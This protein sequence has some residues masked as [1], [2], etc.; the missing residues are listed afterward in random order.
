[1]IAV[2]ARRT[3]TFSLLTRQLLFGEFVRHYSERV[4]CSPLRRLIE[5]LP[6]R[7][8]QSLGQTDTQILESHDEVVSK[9]WIQPRLALS[10]PLS[11]ITS[12]APS[13]S[14]GVRHLECAGMGDSDVV[15]SLRRSAVSAFSAFGFNVENAEGRRDSRKDTVGH[16]A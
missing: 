12:F 9:S 2:L 14:A 16:S 7:V 4:S 8:T 13:G 5:R 10:V 15:P 11:Q 1:M 6:A 3:F